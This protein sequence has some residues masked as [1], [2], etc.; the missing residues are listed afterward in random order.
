MVSQVGDDLGCPLR[1]DRGVRDIHSKYKAWEQEAWSTV[2]TTP[3]PI[4]QL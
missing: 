3:M 4:L 2:A 1:R